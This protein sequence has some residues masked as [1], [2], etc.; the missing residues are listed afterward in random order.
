VF[1]FS[2]LPAAAWYLPFYLYFVFALCEGKNEIQK[3]MKYR[4]ERSHLGYGG[5]PVIIQQEAA[6]RLL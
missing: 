4:C 1:G 6:L 2:A 5:T 3:K